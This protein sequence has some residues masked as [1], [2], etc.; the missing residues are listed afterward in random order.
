M[1]EIQGTLL[2]KPDK[3]A[4]PRGWWI[5]VMGLH[6]VIINGGGT[7]NAQGEKIWHTRGIGEKGKPLPDVSSYYI[8]GLINSFNKYDSA[9]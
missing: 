7:L 1:I 8:T 5:N 4:F 2:G 9:I 6:G 3:E